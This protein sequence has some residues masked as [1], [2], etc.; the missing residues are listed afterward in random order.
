M[1]LETIVTTLTTLGDLNIAPMG[2]DMQSGQQV[3][4]LRPFETSSTYQN[5]LQNPCGVVH[6]T[7]D[8]LLFAQA[9]L[10]CLD[11]VP[12]WVPAEKV[13]GCVLEDCCRWYEFEAVAK[14][15]ES[16][17]RLFHCRVVKT[18][19]GRDFSG[20]NRAKHAVLEATISATRIDFIPIDV[21]QQQLQLFAPIVEKTGGDRENLAFA[22]LQKFVDQR[23]TP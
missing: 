10:N 18:G 12:D 21:I 13:A 17:R 3:F 14:P 15:S 6:I 9:A 11:P 7:D 8:V 19:R 20:F 22:I 5:L 16:P 4:E 1:I 23:S 2:P